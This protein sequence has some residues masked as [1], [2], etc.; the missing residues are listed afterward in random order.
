MASVSDLALTYSVPG[1]IKIIQTT[2]PGIIAVFMLISLV[3]KDRQNKGNLDI[4]GLIYYYIFSLSIA[5]FSFINGG[6][7]LELL[8]RFVFLSLIFIYFW[9][10]VSKLESVNKLI[11]AV[12]WGMFAFIL[13]NL[14][15]MILGIGSL[16]WKGRLFGLAG[17]PNF[18]GL[19]GT[20]VIITSAF[21][22]WTSKR[23]MYK[24][25]YLFAL[26][27]GFWICLLTGS[28]NSVFSS[29]IFFVFFTFFNMRNKILRFIF[30]YVAA[31]VAFLFFNYFSI[32]SLDYAARGNTRAETWASMWEQASSL[33]LFG[34]GKTGA[35]SNSF[36]FA[37]VAAGVIG[38]L[39]LFMSM[40]KSLKVFIIQ[41]RTVNN[42]Y[43]VNF[44]KAFILAIFSAAFF[45]GFLLDTIG[46][47]VFS[48]WLLLAI[49]AKKNN[50][51]IKIKFDDRNYSH[52]GISL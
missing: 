44:R 19:C 3:V 13:S 41:S 9:Q 1:Y 35:T 25:L 50:T 36:L 46:A 30:L 38:S 16:S 20:L 37:V 32:D 10:V 51:D 47:G 39:F 15:M 52:S 22:F 24:I 27:S 7:I 14:I 18:M 49:N 40:I 8:N 31:L 5:L 45:E 12:F 33:P 29:V 2:S 48:Y 6:E 28:R 26:G 21:L 23:F 11:V 34:I 4:N 17:H 43:M 42:Q